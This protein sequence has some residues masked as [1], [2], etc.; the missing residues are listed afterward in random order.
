MK[1]VGFPNEDKDL[2]SSGGGLP[3]MENTKQGYKLAKS[4]D[5]VNLASRMHHQ[6]G[7]VQKGSIQTL[8]AQMEIG[9][10]VDDKEE[11]DP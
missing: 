6:R 1:L 10:V 2:K 4:G 11:S 7:N 9:V 5:G 3:I 8:K